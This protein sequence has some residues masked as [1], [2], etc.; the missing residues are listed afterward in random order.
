MVGP[1]LTWSENRS[2]NFF[3]LMKVVVVA[4]VDLVWVLFYCGFYVID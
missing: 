1:V 2:V 3:F 4:V